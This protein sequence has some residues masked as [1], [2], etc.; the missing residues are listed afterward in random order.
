MKIKTHAI[1][2]VLIL[3]LLI[4]VGVIHT[5]A[6]STT[7]NNGR[8][9]TE[10]IQVTQYI[11]QL[12]TLADDKVVCEVTVEHSGLPTTDELIA[13]CYQELFPLTPAQ[14]ATSAVTPTAGPTQQPT[15]LPF[16]FAGFLKKVYWHLKNTVRID[17]EIQVALP[18][19][20]INIIAPDIPVIRPYVILTAYEPVPA[21]KI[22]SIKGQVNYTNFEC[23]QA[24]CEVPL[25][26]DSVI[27]FW[28]TSSSGDDSIHMQA[29]VRVT[30]SNGKYVV[31]IVKSGPFAAFTDACSQEW[32]IEP[33][34]TWATFPQ[35]P[36]Q[37]ATNTTL[38]FLTARLISSGMVD[39]SNCPG[40]GLFSDG[41]ANACGIQTA[42]GTMIQWQNQFDP[43][44][45]A[46]GRDV[47]IPP[48]ML[49]ALIEAES[50]F[51][52]GNTRFLLVEYGLGQLTLQGADVALRWDPDLYQLICSG[53]L[54]D[55][56]TAYAKLDPWVQMT[57]AGTLLRM[58]SGDCPTCSGSVDLANA[59]SSMPVIARTLRSNCSQV[60]QILTPAGVAESN[61]DDMWR[62]TL[63]SYHS[64]YQ[65]LQDAVTLAKENNE[66]LDWNHVSPYLTCPASERYVDDVWG[67]LQVN[68]IAPYTT[69]VPDAPTLVPTFFPTSTPTAAPTAALSTGSLR[70]VVYIDYNHDNV[71]Q[72]NELVDGATVN[73]NFSDGT[74]MAQVTVNGSAT[75]SFSGK[76]V[77]LAGKV[78]VIS[79]FRSEQFAV[80]SSG[81]V[82]REFQIQ[83]PVLPTAL[84]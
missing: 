21:Y 79:L 67:S 53:L 74:V 71:A 11:W 4:S 84:P 3:T 35:S 5:K 24:R 8:F 55:C 57:L 19:M 18:D 23:P 30:S 40:G 37:L 78:S 51:W 13:T 49:K 77:G 56:T 39:A 48:R 1:S 69:E 20:G 28:A 66:P 81:E 26:G 6:Q 7:T 45:W 15:P 22:V 60:E 25:Q 41:S 64:G 76:V 34:S 68:T 52:P 31:E 38:Y 59:T 43:V 58:V 75:F 17:K 61:Y 36:D 16:D 80:P 29:T 12:L 33:N 82:V 83:P 63:V 73:V 72:A 10:H 62:F 44:I 46:A 27:D 2:F 42:R 54:Y 32:G 14:S 65:C 47:G 50:Q 70:V 9:K